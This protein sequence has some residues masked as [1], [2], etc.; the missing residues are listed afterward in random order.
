MTPIRKNYEYRWET[1]NF[2]SPKRKFIQ[3]C[4]NGTDN[5]SDKIILL[6]GEQGLG[7]NIHL[8]FLKLIKSKA[9]K[10][11]LQIDKKLV[12]LFKVS[13]FGN[14][15]FSNDEELPNFDIHCPLNNFSH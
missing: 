8:N 13:N 6:H 15:I 12:Q 9:K 2:P 10:T 11:I 1:T 14:Y 7:D 3:P 4:W 5:L